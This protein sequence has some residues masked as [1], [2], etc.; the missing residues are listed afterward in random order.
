MIRTQ[1]QGA[2]PPSGGSPERFGAETE[3]K[4]KKKGFFRRFW[5]VFVLV[6]FVG[7]LGLA[8]VI[9]YVY[10]QTEVP[11]APPGPQTTLV[12]DRHGNRIASLHAE[13]DRTIIP[14]KEI[15]K[16]FRDAVIAV[17]DKDFYRHGGISPFAIVRAAWRDIASRR[18]E[19]GGSTI[20]QQYVK[21]V[22]TGSERSFGRK[23][24]EA[25]IAV[26]LEDKYSK[27]E[28]LAK[29]LNTVY[30]GNG[31]YGVQAAA[32]TYWGK[33]ARRLT[34]LE[35][36]TLAGVIPAPATY[37]PVE[38]PKAAKRRRNLVLD[39]MAEQGYITETE[40][41]ELKAKP[42]KVR[43]VEPQQSFQFAYFVSHVSKI[44]QRDFGQEQTFAGGLRVQ[45]T[46]DA[47][48]QRAAEA[49]VKKYLPDA[50]DPSA[51]VIAI[52]PTNG[53]IRA[54]VGGKDFEKA[55]FNLATQARRQTGS[56]FKVF[57][58]AEAFRQKISPRSTWKGPAQITIPDPQCYD[59]Q[60][61]EPWKPSNYGDAGQG[62]MNLIDAT[63]QSVNTIYAQLVV[64]VGPENVAQLARRMGI[65]TPLEPVCSITLGSQSV[66]PLEM[67]N[68]FATL[69]ARGIRRPSYSIASVKSADGEVLH[70]ADPKGER[71]LGEN[72]AD[73]V[74]YALQSVS[75][76]GTGTAA[77]L[78]DRPEAIK[79][80][81]AQDYVDAYLCG[82]VPELVTCVW[83][84]YTKGE[85]PMENVNGYANVFGG[86]IPALIWRDFMTQALANV[87]PATFPTPS[88]AG[89]DKFPN[90][91]E[92][93][94]ENKP[95]PKKTSNPSNPNPNP[96]PPPPVA[97]PPPGPTPSVSPPPPPPPPPPPASPPAPPGPPPPPP[98]PGPPPPPPG[99]EPRYR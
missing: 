13:V 60:K 43:D 40:A 83:V 74:N 20:T 42:L 93:P 78:P 44:L 22:Y 94:K 24:K 75:T 25:I 91:S 15:P 16:S 6:P 68:G 21:N 79:T 26:K 72:D 84:G 97:P 1:P 54:L 61:N 27:N 89:Y 95:K 81:T 58:L 38:N 36:A 90:R 55:K 5:W 82:H 62:K 85:I 28:I 33:R 87:P 64:E 88:F 46:L 35:S 56:A 80:G 4:A 66:T 37:D 29:Y 57:T 71:V 73:L 49:A 47:N 52:D 8:G 14:F 99:P 67:T 51:A 45:T 65:V 3:K 9:F 69:A 41:E 32:Q 12:Y 76:R 39:R 18:I 30:L 11:E 34:T 10:A 2:V 23:I 77:N 63:A 7:I 31:A 19:Q 92:A 86:S 59:Q 98:P 17:E 96:P 50:N 48:Y 70:E 53:A